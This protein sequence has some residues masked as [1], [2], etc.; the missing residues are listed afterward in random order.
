MVTIDDIA[1]YVSH[2]S[3]IMIYGIGPMCTFSIVFYLQCVGYNFTVKKL[4]VHADCSCW[5]VSFFVVSPMEVLCGF[6][7]LLAIDVDIHKAVSLVPLH[8][9][10][11][12]IFS[13][14]NT[15]SIAGQP[16]CLLS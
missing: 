15:H 14:E 5:C 7:S 6:C 2:V 8:D 9:A 12:I 16:E 13:I 11:V 10:D 3:R 4:V 1:C